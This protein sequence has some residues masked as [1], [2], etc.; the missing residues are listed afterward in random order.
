MRPSDCHAQLQYGNSADGIT[1]FARREGFFH[2]GFQRENLPSNWWRKENTKNSNTSNIQS[3][4]VP[5]LLR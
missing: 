4:S 1:Q 2:E 3:A 5:E